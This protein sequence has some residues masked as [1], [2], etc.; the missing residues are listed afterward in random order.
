MKLILNANQYNLISGV[1][2]FMLNNKVIRWIFLGICFFGALFLLY[3]K[4]GG[5]NFRSFDPRYSLADGS[6]TVYS[7]QSDLNPNNLKIT[8]QNHTKVDR[9][10]LVVALK[11]N[12]KKAMIKPVELLDAVIKIIDKYPIDI[13]DEETSTP[14]VTVKSFEKM[15]PEIIISES[16]SYNK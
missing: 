5:D 12:D 7:E 11:K 14:I 15:K 9:A 8:I 2:K 13:E 3:H 6:V 16:Y 10:V 1:M 4:H